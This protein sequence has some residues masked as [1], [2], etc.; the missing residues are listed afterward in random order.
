[1]EWD[2]KIQDIYVWCHHY[3]KKKGGEEIERDDKMKI[4]MQQIFNVKI[5]FK[6][7]QL[8]VCTFQKTDV[9]KRI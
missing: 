4:K 2:I 6:N 9:L 3:K 7:N 8:T 1:M 5:T